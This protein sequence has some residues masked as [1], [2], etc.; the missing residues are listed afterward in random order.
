MVCVVLFVFMPNI[1][2][3]LLEYNKTSLVFVF[4]SLTWIQHTELTFHILRS[5]HV[6]MCPTATQRD[7]VA[8][9]IPPVA[10][11]LLATSP[12]WPYLS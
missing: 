10:C 6:H 8:L 12:K 3:Y 7:G 4:V 1:K 2:N 9:R 5:T 11:S